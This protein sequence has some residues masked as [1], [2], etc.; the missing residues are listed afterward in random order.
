[1]NKFWINIVNVRH[2]VRSPHNV[3]RKSILS[4]NYRRSADSYLWTAN[5]ASMFK[6]F[7]GIA[8]IWVY[9]NVY[10]CSLCCKFIAFDRYAF[11]SFSCF[12]NYQTS[13]EHIFVVTIGVRFSTMSGVIRINSF[14]KAAN[15]YSSYLEPCSPTLSI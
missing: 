6:P 3:M 5:Y 7:I 8:K 15:T 2:F 14:R 4:R 12:H 1:M 9:S 11:C 13:S 10:S